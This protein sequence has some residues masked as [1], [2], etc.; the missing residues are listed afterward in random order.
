MVSFK[1]DFHTCHVV[2]FKGDFPTCG[3]FQGGFSYM[4]SFK[5]DFHTCKFQGGFSYILHAVSFNGHQKIPFISG[6]F[7]V[8]TNCI[9]YI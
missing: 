3:K 6:R 2:S 4:V 8:Y 5:G 7:S 1:G 9:E